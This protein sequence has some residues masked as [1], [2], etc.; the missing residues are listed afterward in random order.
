MGILKDPKAQET[1][2]STKRRSLQPDFS[3]LGPLKP[4]GTVGFLNFRDSKQERRKN[5]KNK[6]DDDDM[7]SDDDDD[8]SILGKADGEEAK[9]DNHHLSPDDARFGGELA[10]GVRKIKVSDPEPMRFSPILSLTKS[11]L[12]RQHSAAS[13]SGSNKADA[14][15]TSASGETNQS[16]S[17]LSTSSPSGSAAD[18]FKPAM[19][20]PNGESVG[21]PLKKQR[22]SV[23]G[24][25][26]NAIRKRIGSG[27]SKNI[28][29]A[30]GSSG[31]GDTTGFGATSTPFGGSLKPPELAPQQAPSRQP[32]E[33]EL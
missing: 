14:K 11:Q 4:G 27:L 12:K 9:E 6:K 25:D 21:S 10:E 20:A 28:T 17:N 5:K 8:D 29:E 19:N 3:N 33:E 1:P 31:A 30:L 23:S 15:D 24:A 16:S 18:L 13:L 26:E 7:D 2:G 32:D 22:A